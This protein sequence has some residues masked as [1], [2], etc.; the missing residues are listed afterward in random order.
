M[1][2]NLIKIGNSRGIIIPS[3]LLTACDLEDAVELQVRD[4]KIIIEAFRQLRVGWFDNYHFETEEPMLDNIP[5]D[6]ND[7]EWTW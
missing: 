7:E 3:S 6:E 2:I 5:V 4:G 1:H